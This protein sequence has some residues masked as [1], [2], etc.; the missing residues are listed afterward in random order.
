MAG[1]LV[2]IVED[3]ALVA[4]DLAQTVR[5][6][7]YEVAG[8]A[9]A[10]TEAIT[11]VSQVKPDVV[12]MDI[13]LQGEKDGIAAAEAINNRFQVP[14]IFVTAHTDPATVQ[15]ARSVR[16]SGY[17][18]KPF[19]TD[20]IGEALRNALQPVDQQVESKRQAS[21]LIVDSLEY[22]QDT[23]ARALPRGHRVRFAGS[24]DA[25]RQALAAGQF[26]VIL[27]NVDMPDTGGPSIRTIRRELG[28]S[29]PI[30]AIT[31]KVDP[32]LSAFYKA[33]IQILLESSQ[34]KSRLAVEINRSLP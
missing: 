27:L 3:Q 9:V 28:V 32:G 8:I 12:L 11:K 34:L 25:A 19:D 16:P 24:F 31:Q 33:D 4:D 29:A 20:Q 2:L 22:T 18:V 30:I 15:R 23:I 6:L 14:V 21:I 26:D 1:G 13:S 10:G 5:K 17:I 7:G